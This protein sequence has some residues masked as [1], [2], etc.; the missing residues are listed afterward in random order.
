[1]VLQAVHSET[2]TSPANSSIPCSFRLT[3]SPAQYTAVGSL[4]LALFEAPRCTVKHDHPKCKLISFAALKDT[5]CW[6]SVCLQASNC[7]K[8]M[9]EPIESCYAMQNVLPVSA[10]AVLSGSATCQQMVDIVV[11]L[12]AA[13]ALYAVVRDLLLVHLRGTM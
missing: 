6:Y 13:A 12:L 10:Q 7:C 1:M 5:M 8:G 3:M 4:H 11:E 2:T 9:E